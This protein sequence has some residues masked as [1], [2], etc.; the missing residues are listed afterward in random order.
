MNSCVTAERQGRLPTVRRRLIC[1]VIAVVTIV[2]LT[3]SPGARDSA[4]RAVSIG[5]KLDT[6]EAAVDYKRSLTELLAQLE[7]YL[8]TSQAALDR[9]KSLRDVGA[10]TESEVRT[11]VASVEST[12]EK[13][14]ATQV[15]IA[16]V[17]IA[18]ARLGG[19][20]SR[21]PTAV[22][23]TSTAGV[24]SLAVE[25]DA[26]VERLA[27]NYQGHQVSALLAKLMTAADLAKDEFETTDHFSERVRANLPSG[28][29]ALQVD[30]QSGAISID[31]N[32]DR[33]V[34]AFA[35]TADLSQFWTP[36]KVKI[37]A[38]WGYNE[39]LSF[40]RVSPHGEQSSL[41]MLACRELSGFELSRS[42]ARWSA[43]VALRPD[44]ARVLKPRI[45]VL[46]IG[47]VPKD[48]N[49]KYLFVRE[50]NR[51]HAL[52]FVLQ[53]VWIYDVSTGTVLAKG[54]FTVRR[55]PPPRT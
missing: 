17:D 4:A 28:T 9:A 5:Q 49:L 42:H 14:V 24:Q 46:V 29:L 27:P 48:G 51:G 22:N 47:R 1:G 7:A 41:L 6:V 37:D 55:P 23:R 39:E 18:L 25:F 10:V 40:L 19:S 38:D 36:S 31:Y 8:A 20:P 26:T 54:N 44:E 45:R 43:E 33:Q 21:P 52:G 2:T 16:E 12:K 3:A 13:I 30:P 32:A 34:M 53:H 11:H 50:T 35:V 15:K